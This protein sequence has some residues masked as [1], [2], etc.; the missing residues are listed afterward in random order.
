[1][2]STAV[3]P[4]SLAVS[5]NLAACSEAVVAASRIAAAT[6]CNAASSSTAVGAALP[7]AMDCSSAC[8]GEASTS[9]CHAA[10][11]REAATISGSAAIAVD[12]PPPQHDPIPRQTIGAKIGLL[13]NLL[14]YGRQ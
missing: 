14:L 6:A 2:F 7:P 13:G 9:F 10:S 8:P 11:E 12:R 3:A 1:M 4:A 5:L